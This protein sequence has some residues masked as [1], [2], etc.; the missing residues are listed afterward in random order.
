MAPK[1]RLRTTRS[2]LPVEAPTQHAST[3]EGPL[4]EG[5]TSNDDL[6]D[7]LHSEDPEQSLGTP[8]EV[9]TDGMCNKWLYFF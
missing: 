1:T 6:G 2:T 4:L 3:G 5:A 7:F 8:R 9:D